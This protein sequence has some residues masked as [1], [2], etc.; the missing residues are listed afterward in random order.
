LAD[1]SNGRRIDLFNGCC[2]ILSVILRLILGEG[3]G[4]FMP[5]TFALKGYFVA[6]ELCLI[7]F[8]FFLALFTSYNHHATPF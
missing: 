7:E 4:E 2:E 1:R 6:F 5:T 8:V 3:E